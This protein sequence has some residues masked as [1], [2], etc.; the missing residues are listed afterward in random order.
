MGQTDHSDSPE[1]P[2]LRGYQN[3]RRSSFLGRE[4]IQHLARSP[5]LAIT[6]GPTFP[7]ISGFVPTE[8]IAA[9]A[10]Y[11]AEHVPNSSRTLTTHTDNSTARVAVMPVKGA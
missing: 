10:W 7:T 1:R 4:P 2:R 9:L 5:P 6:G 11:G 3:G 8:A